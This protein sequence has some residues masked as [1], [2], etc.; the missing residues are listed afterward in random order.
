LF[1]DAAAV[2]SPTDIEALEAQMAQ[3][4]EMA[5]QE[6]SQRFAV[7]ESA[8]FGLVDGQPM[9]SQIADLLQAVRYRA[10]N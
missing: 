1:A 8:V 4:V 2:I 10:S 6:R 3:A 7:A 9:T 5:D